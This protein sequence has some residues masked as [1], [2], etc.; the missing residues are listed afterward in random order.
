[1]VFNSEERSPIEKYLT[2]DIVS[3]H[4]KVLKI[5]DKNENIKKIGTLPAD[6][7]WIWFNFFYVRGSYLKNCEKPIINENRYYYE[8]Y[9]GTENKDNHI[10]DSYSLYANGIEHYNQGKAAEIALSGFKEKQ[11]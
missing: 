6:K 8:T 10:N 1:M 2:K 9:L 3:N 11:F 7:G 5:F 4:K